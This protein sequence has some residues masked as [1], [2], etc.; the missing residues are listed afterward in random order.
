MFNVFTSINWIGVSAAFVAYFILGALWYMV[1]FP[2]PYRISLGKDPDIN[3][4]QAPI[5][6]I[7]PAICTLIITITCAVLM[8]ALSIDSYSDT[9]EF[10]LIVGIGFL[11]TNTVNIAINPNIPRPF[12]YGMIT[13]TYHL[14]ALLIVTLILFV[15][16]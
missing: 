6:I 16:K 3:A 8:Q 15:M 13:G 5:F 4:S 12:L 11:F 7:G 1:L 14:V 2:R 9:F 10:T